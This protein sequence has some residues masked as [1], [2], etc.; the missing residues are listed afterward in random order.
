M[1]TLRGFAD[2]SRGGAVRLTVIS[3]F[4]DR[5]HGTE[6]VLAEQLERLSTFGGIEIHLYAQRVTGLDVTT[7]GDTRG[8]DSGRI[9][10]HKVPAVP[11]PHLLQYFWWFFANR[12]KRAANRPRQAGDEITFSPGINATDADVIAVH[13]VFQAFYDRA[14]NQL[15]LRNAPLKSWPRRL[16]RR[17]YY[18]SIMA[19]EK[20]IYRDPRICLLPVS[21][22]VAKQLREYFGRTDLRVIPNGVSTDQFHPAARAL[23]RDEAR[24][25][26]GLLPGQFVL[27]LIGNDWVKKG[28][29]C[30]LRAFAL[31]G[32]PSLRLLVAG[33]DDPAI[34]ASEIAD[35][36]IRNAVR[37]LPPRE[38]VLGYYAAADLY[39]GPSLEDAFGLPILE[40]MA[41]GLPVIASSYAG[42]SEAIVDRAN[43][44]VLR[45]PE[46]AAE[47]A[48]E[49]KLVAG[50]E[51]LRTSLGAAAAQTARSY[52]WEQNAAALRNV[53]ME[54][55]MTLAAEKN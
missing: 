7:S 2:I 47:L 26:L 11:G 39:V 15:R 12:L 19:L 14:M 24:R 42:A 34:F 17:M 48:S 33:S 18:R 10:W 5:R 46:N 13:I 45:E 51:R 36:T 41:C 55:A 28:L 1:A 3:P 6:R 35:A 23:R 32:D 53:L 16:H 37:F 25:E 54:V 20:R 40:A 52:S 21:Q 8:G 44:L 38:D 22:L 31:C 49:I 50:D 9:I 27:L 29:R 43:G 4:V 30:L